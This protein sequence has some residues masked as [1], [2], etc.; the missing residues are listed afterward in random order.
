MNPQFNEKLLSQ[1]EESFVA[2]KE[3]ENLFIKNC[4]RS[5]DDKKMFLRVRDDLYLSIA[6]YLF[7]DP[8]F[9]VLKPFKSM[10]V[11][12]MH[13]IWETHLQ[14]QLV[15]SGKFVSNEIDH[16]KEVQDEFIGLTKLKK[17]VDTF[18]ISVL[19]Q[20][21]FPVDI[22]YNKKVLASINSFRLWDWL[23]DIMKREIENR[24]SDFKEKEIYLT[25]NWKRKEL[26]NFNRKKISQKLYDFLYIYWPLKNTQDKIP[27]KYAIFIAEVYN[28]IHLP[29]YTR[30]RKTQQYDKSY[31]KQ[32][33]KGYAYKG[34]AK[35]R[36]S[37][38][39]P[40]N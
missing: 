21:D 23:M 22:K 34:K 18:D 8:Q 33:L 13:Q 10:F 14:F 19:R 1:C 20:K 3:A 29:L 9:S 37:I 6:D 28:L 11:L 39:N 12:V 16:Y 32:D 25:E 7:S 26:H 24:T 30:D 15:L 17:F 31:I 5:K 2:F 38:P 35:R 36:L 40:K 27:D 4:Q